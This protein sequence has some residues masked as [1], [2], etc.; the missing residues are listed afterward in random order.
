MGIKASA[1][2]TVAQV[3]DGTDGNG[4][5][6]TVVEYQAGASGTTA[7]TGSWSTSIPATTASA[8]Y[9]WTKV[10][11]TYTD[12]S[13]PKVVYS[14]GSTPEGIVVGGRNLISD[15]QN[16]GAMN[17]TGLYLSTMN[18]SKN[19]E[20]YSQC[21][22]RYYSGTIAAN[23]TKSIV[24]YRTLTPEYGQSYTFSFWAKGS[25]KFRTYFHGAS[26]YVGVTKYVASDGD[27]STL[28]VDGCKA[29]TLTEEW[30][31][32]WITYTLAT[33]G[34]TASGKYLL[35]RHDGNVETDLTISIA[36]LKLEIGNKATDWT[37]APEDV[38]ASIAAVNK[39]VNNAQLEIDTANGK[40][41]T[42]TSETS[43]L[44]TRM[45]TVE[46]SAEKIDFLIT[47]E[48][49]TT[50]FTLTDAGATLLSENLT[51]TDGNGSTV[52]TGGKLTIGFRDNLVKDVTEGSLTVLD[53]KLEVLT[54][55]T[56][57]IT[58]NGEELYANNI[59]S[60]IFANSS[61]GDGWVYYFNK[62][63]TIPRFEVNL[64]LAAFGDITGF[65]VHRTDSL[66]YVVWYENDMWYGQL[67]DGTGGS[68]EW[69]WNSST[70]IVLAEWTKKTAE[71][72]SYQ[73]Y[74]P[75][76]SYEEIRTKAMLGNWAS[77]AISENTMIDGGLLKTHTVVAEK[78]ATDA[79]KSSNYVYSSG[80]FSDSGTFLD[81]SLGTIKSKNFSIDENG[82]VGVIGDITANS[83]NV[84]QYITITNPT[85]G[86]SGKVISYEGSGSNQLSLGGTQASRIASLVSIWGPVTIGGDGNNSVLSC[87]KISAEQI[88]NVY[89][90]SSGEGTIGVN[91][92]MNVSG[93]V[94]FANSTWNKMGDD[95]YIGDCN[96]AGAIGIHGI[97]GATGLYYADHGGGWFMADDT[98]MRTYNSKSVYVENGS[99]YTSGGN[100]L[101]HAGY[102]LY[103]QSTGHWTIRT[104]D[105]SAGMISVGVGNGS[106]PL[107][108]FTDN[109]V[110]KGN[111]TTTYFSTAS[112]SDK[113]LKKDLLGITEAY[114][115]MYM[116]TGVYSFRYILEDDRIHYGFMAQDVIENMERYGIPLDNNLYGK[117]K[118]ECFERDITGDDY[119]Y[120]INYL[121]WIPLNKH[122]ITKTIN[123]LDKFE[124]SSQQQIDQLREELSQTRIDYVEL[125][126]EVKRLKEKLESVA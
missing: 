117:S 108:L 22:V 10:T 42:L 67:A 7:P 91:G 92:S 28:R 41:T 64:S 74:S 8:P 69:S 105:S 72:I 100:F 66:N 17:T 97:N 37:P 54:S 110:W 118:S 123:R 111:S 34:N 71:S 43:S 40:I 109:K 104:F 70:D 1:S 113:R 21:T 25:G 62:R 58:V 14:V 24:E 15:T 26:G 36:G 85:T 122:M 9:L 20:L 80:K 44:G 102:G 112:S 57:S 120:N 96:M 126:T 60:L 79:I 45:S 16:F 53:D 116:D 5:K 88:S 49:G 56:V 93:A 59:I 55:D 121:E 3:T 13:D 32:Y 30:K 73:V 89:T 84:K 31:R 63:V 78:L 106:E 94:N 50:N 98:W 2:V 77:G 82:S 81:L 4:I 19:G 11:Y 65:I 119:T 124:E 18:A 29:W 23:D 47:T 90:I 61:G 52:I 12:G 75:A 99:F 39:K 35:M 125:L 48:T 27:T 83:L 33:T 95:C 103:C 115:K 6:S 76:R 38:D 46:Q 87:A 51:I 68:S 107:R 114:E 86:Q 101:A